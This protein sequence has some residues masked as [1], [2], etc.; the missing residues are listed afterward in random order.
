MYVLLEYFEFGWT[1]AIFAGLLVW[2][3][4]FGLFFGWLEETG[5]SRAREKASNLFEKI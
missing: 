1:G 5:S 2:F 3:L 4:T